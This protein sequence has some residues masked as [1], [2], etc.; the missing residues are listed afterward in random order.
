MRPASLSAAVARNYFK[1]LTYK[2][3]YEVARLYT[4]GRFA[5]AVKTAFDGDYRVHFHLA[6]PLIARI[7]PLTG[8]PIKRQF[9]PW[10]KPLLG[11]LA[12]CKRLRGTAIDPFSHSTERV[13]DRALI[14]EYEATLDELLG[15]LR[16]SN[17]A[18]AAEI[19]SLPERVRGFGPVRA[20]AAAEMRSR[21]AELLA[22]LVLASEESMLAA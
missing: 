13:L 1:L 20:R 18:V 22:Q 4:D 10:A 15:A 14:A 6:P 7:D 2:D 11:L 12:R 9:G 3:E 5:E 16:P 21:R 17:H 19:A 8:E